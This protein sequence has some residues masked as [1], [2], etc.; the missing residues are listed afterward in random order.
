M[1]EVLTA[2]AIAWALRRVADDMDAE[3]FETVLL[4]DAARRIENAH[5]LAKANFKPPY[6]TPLAGE[7]V[8]ILD[9]TK[10]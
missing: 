5:T 6:N 9:G 4:N 10:R 3:N 7:I 8:A 1:S 2:E